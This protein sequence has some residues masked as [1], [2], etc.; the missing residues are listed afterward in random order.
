MTKFLD[1]ARAHSF[2]VSLIALALSVL[3]ILS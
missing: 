3:A 1:W 2:E